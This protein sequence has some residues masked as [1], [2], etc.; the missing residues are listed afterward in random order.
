MSEEIEE[1]DQPRADKIIWRNMGLKPVSEI[2][3]LTGMKPEAVLRRKNE[4][5]EEIDVLTIRQK[6]AK[7][8]VQLDQMAADA[9]DKA[10]T[11]ASEFYAGTI[12]A[13]V[14]AIKTVL[15]ELNRLE[16][17]TTGEVERLNSLRIK[18]LLR[19]MD[20]VVNI[21]VRE[22]ANEYSLDEADLLEIFQSNLVSA[23]QELDEGD[24]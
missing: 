14:S 3:K 16:A 9:R 5:L 13:S 11:I 7:F 17:K 15:T 6:Q 19:L 21:S 20:R 2:A 4:L 12:N 10:E 22:V 24:N 8:M 18:E 23:A 1:F